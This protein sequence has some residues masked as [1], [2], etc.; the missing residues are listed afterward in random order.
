MDEFEKK[1]NYL[2]VDFFNQ[3]YLFLTLKQKNN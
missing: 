1:L 2:I 3:Q